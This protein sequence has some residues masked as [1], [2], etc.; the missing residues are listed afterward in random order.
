VAYPVAG[1]RQVYFEV[2][3]DV[4]VAPGS[5]STATGEVVLTALEPGSAANDLEGADFSLVDALAYVTGITAE[6]QPPAVS[7]R[8]RMRISGP[9]A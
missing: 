3:A 6:G 1:D 7:T 2:S 4:V 8:R 5:T 9:V